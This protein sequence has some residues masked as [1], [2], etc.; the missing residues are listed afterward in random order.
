[1]VCF[2]HGGFVALFFK[3][4]AE[5]RAVWPAALLGIALHFALNF[6]ILFS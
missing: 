4:Y 6:P 5:G 2:L 3:R 1:M